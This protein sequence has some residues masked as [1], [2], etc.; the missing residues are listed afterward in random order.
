MKRRPSG[1]DLDQLLEE[2]GIAQDGQVGVDN[3]CCRLCIAV[4]EAPP[5]I[6]VAVDSNRY[7]I[8]DI[9][10]TT[11]VVNIDSENYML[12]GVDS[13]RGRSC[14]FGATGQ[15]TKSS[16]APTAAVAAVVFKTEQNNRTNAGTGNGPGS[17]DMDM[18]CVRETGSSLGDASSP[19][20]SALA[21]CVST[22][23]TSCARTMSFHALFCSCHMSCCCMC[24][25]LCSPDCHAC[26]HS[27]CVRFAANYVCQR[28]NDLQQT[29]Q[30]QPATAT[31]GHDKVSVCVCVCEC[32]G[33]R[34]VGPYR[35]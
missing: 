13:P 34:T 17:V 8:S 25:S 26:F 24:G 31:L 11:A 32:E 5:S 23:T 29:Q 16:T 20:S 28:N 9:K 3:L 7:A 21:N 12:R 2:T 18:F 1:S 6:A 27:M 33:K 19:D 4:T 14:S 35:R 15:N 30:Q 10:Q 22:A